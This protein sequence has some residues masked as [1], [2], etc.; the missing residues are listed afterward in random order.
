MRRR[1]LLGL[2]L[3]AAVLGATASGA[4]AAT[5]E[6]ST[7][8]TAIEADPGDRVE[9]ALT[10]GHTGSNTT[11]YIVDA[12]LPAEFAAGNGSAGLT[13]EGDAK[14]LLGT[15]EPGATIEMT[16]DLHVPESAAG[17]YEV[18]IVAKTADGVQARATL[19]VETPGERTERSAT[20]TAADGAAGTDEAAGTDGAAGTDTAET[21]NTDGTTEATDGDVGQASA[22]ASSAPGFG[23]ATTLVALVVA[24]VA[25]GR[26]V[27]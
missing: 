14:W 24:I 26:E 23:A 4:T 12:D 7:T 6:L 9:V 17:S 2:V 8:P 21:A 3:A 16:F 5:G 18:P 22:S 15:V 25:A 13:Q 10:L 11:A 27:E 20:T 1:V 19:T